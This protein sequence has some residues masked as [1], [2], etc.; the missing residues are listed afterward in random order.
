MA[1]PS[2]KEAEEIAQNFLKKYGIGA[3][4]TP[5]QPIK[6]GKQEVVEAPAPSPAA[7]SPP[8]KPQPTKKVVSPPSK[9]PSSPAVPPSNDSSP[10][11]RADPPGPPSSPSRA[12]SY[13]SPLRTS[14]RDIPLAASSDGD[15]SYAAQVNA[16]I[17][18]AKRQQ[19]QELEAAKAAAAHARTQRH[20][21]E[22]ASTVEMA[23]EIGK[24]QAQKRAEPKPVATQ[25]KEKKLAE[26]IVDSSD[27]GVQQKIYLCNKLKLYKDQF[28]NDEK[29]KGIFLAN[30]DPT[31]C[32]LQDLKTHMACIEMRLNSGAD[33]EV[34]K[35]VLLW[36][37]KGVQLA[38]TMSGV[39]AYGYESK[40]EQAIFKER[41]FDEDAKQL[42]VKYSDWLTQ[43]PEVR[44]LFKMANLYVETVFE[45]TGNVS[46]GAQRS[47]G[48]SDL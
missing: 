26:E 30:Y 48:R 34:F 31:K 19:L 33:P 35:R 9:L 32:N 1:D 39:R 15:N 43:G 16:Q 22:V 4:E 36:M 10:P 7:P 2:Q 5:Q 14:F 6:D 13:S 18:Q 29:M 45:P 24:M 44:V 46:A 28:G 25:M 41:V 12:A 21:L 27:A 37:A 47:K 8:P 38:S 40:M 3:E 17:E 23:K 42:C 20:K 11:T